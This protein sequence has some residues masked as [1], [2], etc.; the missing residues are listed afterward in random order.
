MDYIL[1]YTTDKQGKANYIEGLVNTLELKALYISDNIR[2]IGVRAVGRENFSNS[3]RTQLKN[4]INAGVDIGRI[5]QEIF[6]Y[7][8]DGINLALNSDVDAGLNIKGEHIVFELVNRYDELKF[9]VKKTDDGINEQDKLWIERLNRFKVKYEMVGQQ[10]EPLTLGRK[11]YTL[12]GTN[13]MGDRL[14]DYEYIQNYKFMGGTASLGD[15]Y[16]LDCSMFGMIDL[17]IKHF[18]GVIKK[19]DSC[20]N[21]DIEYITDGI[22][23]SIVN[24]EIRIHNANRVIAHRVSN[25]ILHIHNSA[26]VRVS[27]LNYSTI[28]F[29]SFIDIGCIMTGYKCRLLH[30]SMLIGVSL[31]FHSGVDFNELVNFINYLLS[32]DDTNMVSSG[33]E[34]YVPTDL[35]QSV[36][37]I[38]PKSCRKWVL[39]LEDFK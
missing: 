19:F 30:S 18:S 20:I 24:A 21:A 14:G 13:V 32:A 2:S 4:D 9:Q 3:L 29:Y 22:F 37:K 1:Y 6:G 12:D 7:D 39:A 33:V 31:V 10:F 11:L 34:L 23:H 25:S 26:R 17:K 5:K 35:Q 16:L 38:L 28:H 8:S 36:L 27:Y 15:V